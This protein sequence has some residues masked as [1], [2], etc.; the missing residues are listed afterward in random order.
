MAYTR[1]PVEKLSCYVL[2]RDSER[3]LEEVLAPLTRIADQ[4]ILLDSGSADRTCEIAARLG[5]EVH[6]RA[7]DDFR[8]QRTHAIALCRYDRVLEV[9]SDE[10]VTPELEAAVLRLKEDGFEHDAYRVRREWWVLGRRVRVVYPLDV[11]DHPVRI[12]D[13]RRVSYGSGNRVHETAGGYRSVGL[14]PATLRHVTFETR[15]ELRRK[16]DQYTS[17][18][19]QDLLDRGA[20]RTFA[21]RWLS[22]VAALAKWYVVKRGF[23]DGRVGLTL[24]CYA[25]EYTRLRY[26]KLAAL[27]GGGSSR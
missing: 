3:H 19:A 9:D 17:I 15:E 22:P 18:S 2:T 5:C 25:F 26:A 24:G 16:L 11:P 10:V 4:V 8:T 23:L 13:R 20:R 6:H 21:K 12:Y 7:F 1:A 27:R 14:V